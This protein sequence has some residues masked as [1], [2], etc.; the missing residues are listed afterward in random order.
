MKGA[1]MQLEAALCLT[2]SSDD[3]NAI[4]VK[5]SFFLHAIVSVM[6]SPTAPTPSNAVS[7]PWDITVLQSI[8]CCCLSILHCCTGHLVILPG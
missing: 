6:Q 8:S 7:Q 4:Y 3:S 5:A 2:S 1:A